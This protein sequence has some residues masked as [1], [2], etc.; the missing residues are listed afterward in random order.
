MKTSRGLLIGMLLILSMFGTASAQFLDLSSWSELTLDMSGGQPPGNW[1]L[2]NL[3][4]TVTQTVNADPSFYLNNI[5]QFGYEMDG[6]WRV[7]TSSDD[8]FMGFV[9]GY[10]DPSHFYLMD[11]KQ[12]TQT[13]YGGIA[14]EGFSI[15]K[16][17]ANSVADL[18]LNDFWVSTGAV[19]TTL[20]DSNYGSTLGWADNTLYDFHLE[21]GSGTFSIQVNQGTN[22]LWN[23]TVTDPSYSHGQFGFYNF[24][25]EQVEYSGFEQQGGTEVPEPSTMLLLSSGLIGLAWF[26]RKRRQQ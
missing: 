13:A 21:F 6:S 3:N 24:S 18:T 22:V 17:S 19:H 5:D 11:W 15:K 16:I 23:T 25:Q 1:V 20:L 4:H 14:Q 9:F 10:Q 2:S 7:I 26:N 12:N 8:D